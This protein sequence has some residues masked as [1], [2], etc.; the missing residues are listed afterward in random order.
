MSLNPDRSL[1]EAERFPLLNDRG[2]AML[3][4]LLEHPQ[5]PRYT[6]PCGDRLDAVG[7]EQVRAFRRRLD[8]ERGMLNSLHEPPWLESF[9]HRCVKQ[10]PF[11][12]QSVVEPRPLIDIPTCSRDDLMRAPWGFVPDDQPLDDLLVYFTTGTTGRRLYVYSHPVVSS[13]YL[14]SLE[15]LLQR[16]GID[17]ARGPDRVAIVQICAQQSTYTHATVSSYLDQAGYAKINLNPHDWRDPEHRWTFLEDCNPQILTG[18]PT[19]FL[20]LAAAPVRIRPQALVSSAMMLLPETRAT[21]SARFGCPVFDTYSLNEARMVAGA[22][23]GA[24]FSLIAPDLYVEILDS[25]G[26][27][28]AAGERGEITLTGGRNPFLPLLRYRT[29]DY[30][31]LHAGDRGLELREFEGRPP[32][33]FVDAQ[34]LAVNS[35]DVTGALRTFPLAQFRIHQRAD[36]SL[37]VKVR[38]PGCREAELRRVLISLFGAGISM[39]IEELRDEDTVGGKVIPYRCDVPET[40]SGKGLPTFAWKKGV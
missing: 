35:I 16:E 31:S 32:V 6:F 34:G 40:M 4:R 3:K 13:S 2:R 24:T 14:A 33:V 25:Q 12:R 5:A 38:G 27:R 10:V 21:L 19:V 36:R 37:L 26:R 15:W 23:E 11:Y 20:A 29:G 8:D 22:K 9:V 17:L 28:C 18:D 7:L 39:S 1:T 30:A